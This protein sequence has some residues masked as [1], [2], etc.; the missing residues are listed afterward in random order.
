MSATN[1]TISLRCA[2]S[3]GAEPISLEEAK[4]YLRI[5]HDYED[6]MLEVFISAARSAAEGKTGRIVKPSVWE[7]VVTGI[8]DTVRFPIAPCSGVASVSVEGVTV[9]PSLYQVTAGNICP[10]FGTITPLSGFPEGTA[11]INL[12]AGYTSI[13]DDMRKWILTRIAD[14][15]EQRE[16]FVVGRSGQT[17][18]RKFVD[19][20][21][22][23]YLIVE[24]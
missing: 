13:P 24:V 9:D 11:T 19:C 4:L 22:D 7:W 6:S 18:D 12:N 2:D 17:F 20:L 21:L 3:S 14:F 1:F 5:D 8:S 15:Y 10:I 16:S 23:P